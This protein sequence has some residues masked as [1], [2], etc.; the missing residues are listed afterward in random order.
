MPN[1][2]DSSNIAVFENKVLKEMLEEQ[3]TTALDMNQFITTDYSL[4]AAPG[5]KVEIHTYH[6]NGAV[7]DLAM[8]EGNTQD[9]G[10]YFTSADYEVTTTQ[11]RIP[12][13]D[14]QQMVDPTAIDKAVQHLAELMTNDVTAK[15]VGELNKADNIFYNFAFDFDGI[16]DAIATLPQEKN[17]GLFLLISRKDISKFQ[18]NLKGLLSYTE[19]F[20]RTGAIGAIAGVPIYPTD[21]LST[22]VAFLATREAVTCFVKKGVETEQERNANTRQTIIYGRNVKV[23]ALTNAD[24]VVKLTSS[25]FDDGQGSV[26]GGDVPGGDPNQNSDPN[27]L[28]PGEIAAD[29]P[30]YRWAA[31]TPIDPSENPANLGWYEMG[32]DRYWPSSDTVIGDGKTY[33]FPLASGHTRYVVDGET[34]YV[35]DSIHGIGGL[36]YHPYNQSTHGDILMGDGT[37]FYLDDDTMVPCLDIVGDGEP[38]YYVFDDSNV[39]Y[40]FVAGTGPEANI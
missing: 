10:A 16:V 12:F 11:G 29:D 35:T 27:A 34:G 4:Q 28:Q 6:G 2:Y 19:D 39:T 21:A 13:Y 32:A 33:Y 36:V 8:S 5:M 25:P 38:E 37:F 17:E 3:L 20:V 26:P 23:I 30:M 18:K 22:G 7:E 14:E 9:I 31:V 15:V 1:A 24:K 40:Y